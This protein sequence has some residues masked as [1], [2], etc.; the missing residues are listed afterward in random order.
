[1]KGSVHGGPS[2]TSNSGRRPGSDATRARAADLVPY[3]SVWTHAASVAG[4]R[5]TA[6]SAGPSSPSVDRGIV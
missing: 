5:V 3:S 6:S 4:K 2:A 1:M